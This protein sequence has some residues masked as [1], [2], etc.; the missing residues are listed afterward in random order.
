MGELSVFHR[1]W[2]LGQ[3]KAFVTSVKSSELP[4]P[5]VW[6]T[7]TV[8]TKLGASHP[9]VACTWEMEAQGASWAVDRGH[10]LLSVLEAGPAT[11]PPNG[12]L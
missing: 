7:A 3:K 12:A 10:Q 4:D 2:A 1:Q 8:D 11:Y 5:L 9:A 6:V